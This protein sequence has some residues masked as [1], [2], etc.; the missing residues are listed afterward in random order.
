MDG[1]KSKFNYELF[2]N[3]YFAINKNKYTK[4]QA[5]SIFQE[6]TG[7]NPQEFLTGTVFFGIGIDDDGEK[8]NTWWLDTY[9]KQNTKRR[10]LVWVMR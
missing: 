3:G 9:Y 2:S 5:I 1:R 6:E 10:C 8:H 7:E 4:N